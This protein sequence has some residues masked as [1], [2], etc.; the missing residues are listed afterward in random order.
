MDKKVTI[1]SEEFNRLL[2]DQIGGFIM[3]GF[4]DKE[5]VLSHIDERLNELVDALE[6]V[7]DGIGAIGKPHE[8]LDCMSEEEAEKVQKVFKKYRGE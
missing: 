7:L 2:H 5:A 8:L 4:I 1:D 6:T 3:N